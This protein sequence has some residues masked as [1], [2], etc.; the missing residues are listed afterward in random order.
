MK[1][2]NCGKEVKKNSRFCM[3]C[4]QAQKKEKKKYQN[5]YDVKPLKGNNFVVSL[6][7]CILIIAIL[8]IILISLINK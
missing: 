1:C 7:F 3:N 6:V 4:G 5:Q 8:F 2:I